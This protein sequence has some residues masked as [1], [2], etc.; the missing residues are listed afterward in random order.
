MRFARLAPWLFV[1][2][3]STGFVVAR[4]ATNDASP[5]TFLAIRMVIAAT[6]LA[7]IARA[8]RAPRISL[9]QASIA[10]L[11]GVGMHAVYLGG[12]FVAI[13][14]GLPSGLSA[15][16]AGLHPVVTAVFGRMV[17]REHLRR[18]QWFGVILGLVGVV[19]VVGEKLGNGSKSVTTVAI[20]AMVL[21]I[22]GISSGTL[23]QRAR[24]RDMP[25]LRGTSMQYSAAALA[26]VVAIPFMEDATVRITPQFLL[27]LGWATL[28]LSLGAVLIMM[29]LLA[30]H[31]AAR[32]SSLFFLT[33]ALSA[34]E[35]AVL[36]G[37]RM[38]LLAVFGLLVAGCGVWLTMREKPSVPVDAAA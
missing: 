2:L 36:F 22:I 34:L 35:G 6:L 5:L 7:L 9:N 15:L 26:L 16:I 23:I 31:S 11:V 1:A 13:D 10:G 29:R 27:A 8:T 4:Y 32:V 21:S 38:G 3:W 37:E 28:V 30:S 17:L 18:S 12:V 19:A 20:V 14:R 25:L 33:P 24:G